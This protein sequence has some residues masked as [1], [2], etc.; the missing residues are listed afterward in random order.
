MLTCT[1]A[2]ACEKAVAV[3]DATQTKRGA[4]R[5]FVPI[6]TLRTTKLECL[7]RASMASRESILGTG[8][9]ALGLEVVRVAAYRIRL[10]PQHRPRR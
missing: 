7:T 4:E 3:Q 5:L 2:Q 9:L 10:I 6:R 8:S 1:N